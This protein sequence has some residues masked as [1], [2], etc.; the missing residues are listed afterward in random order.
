MNSNH[1][2][3]VVTLDRI[4]GVEVLIGFSDGTS[5][6]YA[7]EELLQLRPERGRPREDS[8]DKDN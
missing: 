7:V 2:I 4:D 1:N 8:H 6:T 3:E 5:A